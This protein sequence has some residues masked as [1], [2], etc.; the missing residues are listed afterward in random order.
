MGM[1]LCP[2]RA[3]RPWNLY[4]T[5]V[6]SHTISQVFLFCCLF[7]FLFL[8]FIFRKICEVFES[9]HFFVI[10]SRYADIK[11]IRP[12]LSGSTTL[13]AVG[14]CAALESQKGNDKRDGA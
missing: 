6:S 13:S 10:A 5:F 4:Q 12:S 7:L 11:A 14:W 1:G 9:F 3:S 2:S 8:Y